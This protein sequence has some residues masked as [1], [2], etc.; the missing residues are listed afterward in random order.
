MN[1][2]LTRT[3]SGIVYIAIL[4]AATLY[5]QSFLLLFGIFLLIAVAEFCELV[6]LKR[7]VPIAIAIGAYLLF[8]FFPLTQT[9]E[10][11]LLV[12]TLLVSVKCMVFLFGKHQRPIDTASKYVYLIGYVILPIVLITKIPCI[13]G[14]Y[15]PIIII[16]IFV[17][18]WANDTFAFVVGKSIGKRKL[19]ERISPK[20]TIEGFLGGLI[21]ALIFAVLIAKYL[22][23][24][25]LVLWIGISLMVSIFGTIGDLI[26][27]KFKRLAGVKDSGKIMPGHGG[28]LDR[29]DSIIFVAPFVFLLYQTLHY[30]S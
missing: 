12:A 23:F 9:T 14:N 8:A 27:S 13:S 15:N 18:I 28:I 1:E 4:V 16:G 22:I 24:E 5:L 25:P 21:F 17:L 29:L 26:E 6:H 7:F 10:W 3:L 20:K 30:V 11:L 2:T 19:F